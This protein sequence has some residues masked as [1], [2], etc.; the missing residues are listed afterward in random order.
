MLQYSNV[1]KNGFI[2]FWKRALH[3]EL[4]VSYEE[5][6]KFSKYTTVTQLN[7]KKQNLL[8]TTVHNRKRDQGVKFFYFLHSH[9]THTHTTVTVRISN[10]C[11]HFW[12]V[13]CNE[14]RQVCSLCSVIA[15]CGKHFASHELSFE[16]MFCNMCFSKEKC[17]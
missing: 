11:L 5:Y 16:N 1:F 15:D 8:H 13:V 4:W 17:A 14:W 9:H 3:L 6:R 10:K 7:A 12:V 2:A